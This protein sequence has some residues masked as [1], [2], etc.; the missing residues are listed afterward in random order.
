MGEIE[1]LIV[2]EF[3]FMQTDARWAVVAINGD[4]TKQFVVGSPLMA[5]DL[6]LWREMYYRLSRFELL[7]AFLTADLTLF[8][9]RH[10]RHQGDTGDGCGIERRKGPG[11]TG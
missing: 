5:T 1:F 9:H 2:A 3:G 4:P 11:P 8:K 7:Q 6:L 10:Q